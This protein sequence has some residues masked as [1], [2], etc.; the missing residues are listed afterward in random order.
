MRILSLVGVLLM[1]TGFLV[2]VMLPE[3]GRQARWQRL[4]A[5]VEFT[6]FVLRVSA[7]AVAVLLG[8][9]FLVVDLSMA[10]V[11]ECRREIAALREQ[12]ACRPGSNG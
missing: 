7:A 10:R 1:I 8:V 3:W 5:S 11:E 12:L 2:W 9:V 4:E 6:D